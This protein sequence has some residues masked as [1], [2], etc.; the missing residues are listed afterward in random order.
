MIAQRL[1]RIMSSNRAT[2]LGVG[3][4][5]VNCVDATIELANETGAP[6]FLIASRRQIESREMGGGYVNNWSTEEFAE[7]VI[8]ADKR[9]KVVLCRDHGGPWQ[10]P[11]EVSGRYSLRTAMESA[12]RSYEADIRAGFQIIH[13][14]PSIDIHAPLSVSETL[15]RIYE[16]YEFCWSTA[17]SLR[18]DII[19]EIGT[20]EQ[21]QSS[22]SIE[23]LRF[24]LSD[25]VRFCDKNRFPKPAF[26]VVQ[27]GTR[28]METRNIGS[29]DSPFR[30]AG[31]LPA[32]VQVPRML[33]VCK[34]YGVYMKVHNTD[35]L[36]DESLKW[37]PRLG[38]HSANIAPE[39]GVVETRALIQLLK[40]N[41]LE[42]ELKGFLD[43]AYTSRKWE[44]WMCPDTQA[45]DLDRAVIAGHYVFAHPQCAEIKASAQKTL[46]SR[47][48]IDACLKE[49]VKNSIRRYLSC[50]KMM[51][52]ER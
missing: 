24:V 12:K 36:S 8:R 26:V 49:S 27:T 51:D 6:I 21:H 35:Y 2:L 40:D 17:T 1:D 46:G 32:E 52:V 38:I 34:E 42:T 4:M 30:I 29:F 25:V 47:V 44:K 15:D 16:L 43:L 14:D 45:S 28:V 50:F 20:D 11:K 19:F 48:D 13:I 18:K 33:D 7:Y 10:N 22:S 3:P 9:G 37:Y 23:E 5:S 31:E 39:F 41:A